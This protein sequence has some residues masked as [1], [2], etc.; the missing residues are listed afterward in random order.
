MSRAE[1]TGIHFINYYGEIYNV[2]LF[3][4][5]GNRLKE[6]GDLISM[7]LVSFNKETNTKRGDKSPLFN[8]YQKP[9]FQDVFFLQKRW[10]LRYLANYDTK[11]LPIYKNFQE[12]KY[13]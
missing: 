4:S 7:D 8:L 2:S 10:I 6:E 9:S 1:I 11:I 12:L 13:L 5:L 3:D